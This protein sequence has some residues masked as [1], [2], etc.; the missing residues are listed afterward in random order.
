MFWKSSVCKRLNWRLT[1]QI[2][3]AVAADLLHW[4]TD[5][6]SDLMMTFKSKIYNGDSFKL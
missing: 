2:T 4:L 5:F 6:R 1:I 3:L